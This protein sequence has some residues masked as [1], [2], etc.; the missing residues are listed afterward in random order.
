MVG[1]YLYLAEIIPS[2]DDL[3]QS[4]CIDDHPVTQSRASGDDGNSLK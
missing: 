3:F 1:E 2:P 4:V